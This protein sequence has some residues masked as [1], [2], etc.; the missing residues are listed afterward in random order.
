MLVPRDAFGV[1]Q[2]SIMR[3][4]WKS[5]TGFFLVPEGEDK[6]GIVGRFVTVQ[7][8]ISRNREQTTSSRA[9]LLKLKLKT[10]PTQ[11]PLK[12]HSFRRVDVQRPR[13]LLLERRTPA[14]KHLGREHGKAI[15]A[16]LAG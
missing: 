8:R 4:V 3:K 5:V 1:L 11:I 15:S 7:R 13:L 6:Y 14:A 9:L 2:S 10:L 12:H 16:G